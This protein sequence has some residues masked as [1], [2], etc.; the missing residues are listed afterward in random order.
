M[1]ILAVTPLCVTL[2]S[3]GTGIFLPLI[4]KEYH[5]SNLTIGWMAAL[6]YLFA[7]AGMILWARQVDQKGR[8]IVNL[9]VACL[10][11]GVGL[12]APIISGSV[13]VAVLGFSLALVGVTSARG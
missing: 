9:A 5:L 12:V 3:Y 11:G 13:T 1:L 6:P 4:L 10:L 7:S 8:R 2:V